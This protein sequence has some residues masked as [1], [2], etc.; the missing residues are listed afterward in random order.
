LLE[1]YV[2]IMVVPVIVLLII[3]FMLALDKYLNSFISFLSMNS[4]FNVV[5]TVAIIK[6]VT[7]LS[8]TIIIGF[9]KAF[10]NVPLVSVRFESFGF[11]S[12]CSIID[13]L[14]FHLHSF[15]PYF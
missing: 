14:N 1:L 5:H 12:I 15:F 9:V 3:A 6:K 10:F 2:F 7:A 8:Q 11:I 4:L 13:Y